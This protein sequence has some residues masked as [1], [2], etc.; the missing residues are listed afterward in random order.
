MRKA[1]AI[2]ILLGF[3]F[4]T[5]KLVKTKVTDNITVSIPVEFYPMTEEDIVQR[6]P[7]VRQPLGAYTDQDRIVDFSAN[8]SATQWP[9]AN[10]EMA[11]R[12]FKAGMQ[13]LYDR[14]EFIDEGIKGIKKKQY[15]Y[16][17]FESRINGD[18]YE[19]GSKEPI[20]K[21]TYIQ[22]LVE[23]GRTLV[24]TFNCPRSQREVWQ[25]TA[26]EIMESIRVK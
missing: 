15:I 21:Y 23:P 22:Y 26:H 18:R 19:L 16:F 10:L 25:E 2:A 5:H 20:L 12:F 3:G 11:S 8:I 6:Y 14:V 4:T 17:E 7:S 9:D 24:F 13:N 1:L